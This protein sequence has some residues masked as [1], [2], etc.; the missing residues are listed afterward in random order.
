MADFTSDSQNF[1]QSFSF[2]DIDPT[3]ESL[4]QFT[5]LNQ[6]VVDNSSLNYQS[7]LPFSGDNFFSG[8]APEILQNWGDNLPGFIHHSNHSSVSVAQPIVTAR[9]EFHE[10][11]KRKALDVLE[12]SSGNSSCPRVSESGIKRRNNSG[13][14]KRTKSNEK[15]EKP[16]EVVHVRARRGQATDSH[17]LA[18]RVRRGKINERLRCLQDI[19]PGCYKTMGMAVMLDEIINYVQSLQNQVEFLSMKLTAA[20]TYY[21]FNSESD[22]M[23]RMQREKAKEA[24]ELE[25][26]MREGYVGGLACFHS[27]ST[28]SSLTYNT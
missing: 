2:L 16:K 7:F 9:T 14:G 10:S 28:W 17:S 13:R 1:K 26:L 27:S 20:S 23:E 24:K 22:A 6:S 18:E 21:D 4:T 8:Q 19:V 25:R 11:K 12:S 5:E 3:M 15:E